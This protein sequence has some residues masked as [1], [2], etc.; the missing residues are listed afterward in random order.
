MSTIQSFSDQSS[1]DDS[2]LKSTGSDSTNASFKAMLKQVIMDMVSDSVVSDTASIDSDSSTESF[3]QEHA[4]MDQRLSPSTQK[5]K[6]FG[7]SQLIKNLSIMSQLLEGPSE[8]DDNFEDSNFDE[9][10]TSS[11]LGDRN[12]GRKSKGEGETKKKKKKKKEKKEKKKQSSSRSRKNGKKKTKHDNNEGA[13]LFQRIK[14]RGDEQEAKRSPKEEGEF[15]KKEKNKRLPKDNDFPSISDEPNSRRKHKGAGEKKKKKKRSTNGGKKESRSKVERRGVSISS[16]SSITTN[17]MTSS[18]LKLLF[19]ETIKDLYSDKQQQRRTNFPD[20]ISCTGSKEFSDDDGLVSAL[21]NSHHSLVSKPGSRRFNQEMTEKLFSHRNS[22][23]IQDAHVFDDENTSG[24]SS[25]NN[26]EVVKSEVDDFVAAFDPNE[27]RCLALVSHNE[28]KSSMKE[29]VIKY[30]NVLKKFR[31]TGTNS[32]MKMLGQVFDGDDSVIF[33]PVCKSGPLG[34]DAEL[35]AMMAT[36]QLGGILFF[37]DPMTSHPHQAD[38][39]CLV[40]QAIVH[41]TVIATTPTTAMTIMEPFRLALEGN[42]RPEL[43]PSFF[44]SLASPTVEAYKKGQA[45]II[46]SKS[47]PSLDKLF[48]TT[49]W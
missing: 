8:I 40:R 41:N 2:S 9:D 19:K 12:S 26:N 42:G 6:S 21:D 43:I 28:M 24:D 14:K 29:F 23:C 3:V 11:F 44:F 37:Q 34:G 35:V 15:K 38:I 30:K 36:G 20:H 5:K 46:K 16:K 4:K 33:G 47:S 45:R 10:N 18:D 48:N 1:S 31:L 22:L 25:N 17:K 7:K 27:M 49:R 13:L 32:T 39:E